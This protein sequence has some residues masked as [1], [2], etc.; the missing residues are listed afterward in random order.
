VHLS[1]RDPVCLPVVSSPPPQVEYRVWNPFRSKLAASILAGVDNIYVK[2]GSK[3]LYL[4]AASGTSVSHCSDLVGPGETR[5][6]VQMHVYCIAQLHVYSLIAVVH[7][8]VP[9]Y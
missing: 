5:C 2:P 8:G 3:L 9:V 7:I 1:T 4:G 6:L